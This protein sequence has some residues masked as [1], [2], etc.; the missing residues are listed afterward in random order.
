[1]LLL[2]VPALSSLPADTSIVTSATLIVSPALPV[3]LPLLLLAP[4]WN[5]GCARFL[6]FLL[7]EV[8][9]PFLLIE[10]FVFDA[11]VLAAPAPLPPPRPPATHGSTIDTA[12]VKHGC[13]YIHPPVE[14]ERACVT[15]D[16]YINHVAT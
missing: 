16:Q 12:A 3:A 13:Q 2:A 4:L 10:D 5:R 14:S 6:C 9:L 1:M 8:L 11:V 15:I 7:L